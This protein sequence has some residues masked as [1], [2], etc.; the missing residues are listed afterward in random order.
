[1]IGFVTGLEAEVRLLDGF[2]VLA[3][4]GGGTP[5]GAFAAAKTLEVRPA[6]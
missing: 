5:Q 1:M 3:A 6:G 4:A 2:G